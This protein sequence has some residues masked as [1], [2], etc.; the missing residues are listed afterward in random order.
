VTTSSIH[1]NVS[2]G[3]DSS[4]A[5]PGPKP[6]AALLDHA[7]DG[8]REYDN[9][10]PKWWVMIFWAS[11]VFS[12]GY[13]VHYHASPRGTSVAAAYEDEMR[14]AREERAKQSLAEAPSEAVL[15]KLMADS[16]LMQDASVTFGQRCGPCH[17]PNGQGLIGPNLTDPQWIHGK[18]RLMDIYEVVSKGVPN[19]GMPAWDLQL[20]PIEVR[21][22]VGFVGTL[23]G[24]NLPGKA[25]EG[26]E[27][28]AQ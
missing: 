16:A 20:K 9:P 23:R 26:H 24:K 8:I 13:A 15:T 12:I 17:G 5:E 18:G 4:E 22:I 2:A 25:P 14:V 21:K 28:A 1:P 3:D 6:S 10:L 19:K 7:Y 11:I 27:P